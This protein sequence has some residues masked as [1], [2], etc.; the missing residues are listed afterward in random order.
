LAPVMIDSGSFPTNNTVAL[1]H[2]RKNLL[3][4]SS[5][6]LEE[7]H[8]KK[9]GEIPERNGTDG[10]TAGGNVMDDNLYNNADANIGLLAL[11]GVEVPLLRSSSSSSSSAGGSCNTTRLQSSLLLP[12]LPSGDSA[13]RQQQNR[14]VATA[15]RMNTLAGLNEKVLTSQIMSLLGQN[16]SSRDRRIFPFLPSG[17]ISSSTRTPT[18]QQLPKRRVPATYEDEALA[19]IYDV[20]QL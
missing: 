5:K 12:L 7:N 9:N 1:L 20:F 6:L 15:T 3:L 10:A 14:P 13:K 16:P 19:G 11:G 18:P 8:K 4:A 17:G 2:Q